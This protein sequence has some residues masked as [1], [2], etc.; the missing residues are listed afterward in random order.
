[1]LAHIAGVPFEEW[2][3]PLA[4]TGGGIFVA[5]RVALRRLHIDEPRPRPNAAAA[6]TDARRR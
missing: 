3:A 6:G 4:T 5:L 1:M 2:L